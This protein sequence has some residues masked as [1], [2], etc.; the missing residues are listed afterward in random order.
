MDSGESKI[1]EQSERRFCWII[2]LLRLGGIP[3][4]MR[5]LSTI[6]AI[7]MTTV[8][9]CSCATVLGMFAG[10]YVHW[11]DLG[12]A[13]TL[14]RNLIPIMDIFWIYIYYR[15]VRTVGITVTVSL[16]V[17]MLQY[18]CCIITFWVMVNIQVLFRNY[19][20][21]RFQFIPGIHYLRLDSWRSVIKS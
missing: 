1:N 6:Y 13:M 15:Y 4:K 18:H 21:K 20:L 12:R 2:V 11:D 8:I 14:M 7:Y 19:D 17:S 16:L 10:L 3:F 9:I 5:K